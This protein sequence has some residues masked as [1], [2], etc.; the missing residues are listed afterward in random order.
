MT[1]SEE[2]P[3]GCQIAEAKA[4]LGVFFV[5][6][7]TGSQYKEQAENKAVTAFHPRPLTGMPEQNVEMQEIRDG[8][9]DVFPS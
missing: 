5:F 1:A 9:E 4:F 3:A 8:L 6:F 7:L 2:T